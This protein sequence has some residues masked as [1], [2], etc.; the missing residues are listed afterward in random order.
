[1]IKE[2]IVY[3][4]S[5]YFIKNYSDNFRLSNINVVNYFI[6]EILDIY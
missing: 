6:A 1:M 4:R 3:K 5:N 2:I